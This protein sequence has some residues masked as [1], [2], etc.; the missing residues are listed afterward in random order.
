MKNSPHRDSDIVVT[1]TTKS[2]R[3]KLMFAASAGIL[4]LVAPSGFYGMRAE[5]QTNVL[6]DGCTD[7]GPDALAS[8]NGRAGI[9]ETVDCESAP[10]QNI[11]PLS[12]N[13][14]DLTVRVGAQNSTPLSTTLGGPNTNAT[15]ISMTG[16]G[17]QTLNGSGAAGDSIQEFE[18]FDFGGDNFILAGNHVG[19]EEAN[20]RTGTTFLDNN[21]SLSATTGTIFLD[22]TLHARD[23][24]LFTG[25]LINNG[26]LLIGDSPGVFTIDGN[27]TQ[28]STGKLPIEFEGNAFD[29]LII[30]GTAEL[31]GEIEFTLLDLVTPVTGASFPILTAQGGI[32]NN[33]TFDNVS[34]Q[35]PDV[36]LALFYEENRVLS[37]FVAIGAAPP[38]TAPP[39]F[40]APPPPPPPPDDSG[41]GDAGDPGDGGEENPGD[42]GEETPGDGGEET[43]GDGGEETPGDGG[44][45]TP[46][47]GDGGEDPDQ[48]GSD[49]D[50]DD[51]DGDTGEDPTDPAE[52]EPE[53]E[54]PLL[55]PKEIAPSALMAGMFASDLFADS[56]IQRRGDNMSTGDWDFWVAGLGGRYDVGNN[57]EVYGWD[58][59]TSGFGFGV[60]HL[61]EQGGLP[62]LF[63]LSTGFTESDVDSGFS[64]A[65]VDSLHLGGFVNTQINGFFFAASASHAWQ[66]YD[67]QRVFVFASSGAAIAVSETEGKST[68]FKTE[69]YYDL[70]WDGEGDEGFGF[71]P[72]L[73]ADLITG[74]YNP[75]RETGAGILNLSYDKETAQQSLLGAGV[76]GEYRA[77]LF[78][79]TLVDTG[80]RVLVESVSGD[81]SVT[82]KASLA[83]PGA[84]FTPRSAK[85]D[86]QRVAFGADAK[87]YFSDKVYGH[88]RYDTTQSD[89]FSEHKGWAGITFKF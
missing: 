22:A 9:R 23:Q 80:M 34:D 72:L 53:P 74:S 60:Q 16:G 40:G 71:G 3:N 52:P 56:L 13:V 37:T 57:Q 48:G 69:G 76:Q 18:I 85:L 44:E 35:I 6:P 39:V 55:S 36:D 62:V 19:W 28:S 65:K 8:N 84:A 43:P 81:T 70:L 1:A 77:L 79:N 42:G 25:N 26:T 10:D 12:T 59:G 33:S 50:T 24:S 75:F 47:D 41:D 27:F 20:F 58:G 46:V 61:I 45:E 83:L 87:V 4:A 51:P 68:A 15:A 86:N 21:A 73:T 11:D 88:I 2:L 78:G 67:L 54:E 49:P 32:L 64:H 7:T 82:G 89:Q 17:E 14:A 66:D 30:M 31:G 5:A 63:G 38:A 29:Q